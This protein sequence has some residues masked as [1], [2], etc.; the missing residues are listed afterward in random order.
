MKLSARAIRDGLTAGL[1]A[2]FVLAGLFYTYLNAWLLR[3]TLGIS[4]GQILRPIRRPLA[5]AALMV[6]AVLALGTIQPLGLFS[7]GGSWLSLL[8]KIAVG[9]AVFCTVQAVIWRLEGRP[10]GIERRLLQVWSR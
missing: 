2:G 1:L 7:A 3:R 8:A 6:A 5:A 9:G 10:P 4:P